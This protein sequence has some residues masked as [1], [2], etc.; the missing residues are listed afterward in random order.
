[1]T[2]EEFRTGLTFAEVRAQ[3]WSGNDDPSTWHPKRRR[4]VLGRWYE[5]KQTLW[6]EHIEYCGPPPQQEEDDEV[7]F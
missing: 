7:P 4:T 5:I 2:Y 6:A 1:M 3:F